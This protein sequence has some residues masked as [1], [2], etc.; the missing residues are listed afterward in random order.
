[1]CAVNQ[2]VYISQKNTNDSILSD[3]IYD[4][5]GGSG[6]KKRKNVSFFKILIAPLARI[7]RMALFFIVREE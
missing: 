1:M 7:A 2:E 5:K 4:F 6:K 3:V